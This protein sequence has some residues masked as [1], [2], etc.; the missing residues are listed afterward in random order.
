MIFLFKLILSALAL[1]NIGLSIASWIISNNIQ[2]RFPPVGEFTKING[3]KLHFVDT[4]KVD[5]DKPVVI[6]IHGAGGNLNDPMPIYRPALEQKL[7][8]VFLDRPGQGYSDSFDGSSNIEIQTSSIALLMEKLNIEKAIIVGHSFG[9]AI[10][11]SFAVLHP[12]KTTG[13]VLLAP[14]TH[15]WH[16]GV[17]WH[18]DLGN[19]P[20]IGWIFSNTIAP[21]AGSFI[22]PGAIKRLFQ[23]NQ[24]PQDYSETSATQLALVPRNFHANAKD[25]ARLH[26][27]VEA[28]E[29]RYSE[30]KAPTHIY[31]G[32][33]DDIVSLEI[34]SI[35][36]LSKDIKHAKLTILKDVGHKPDYVASDQIINS[37]LEIADLN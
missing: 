15:P 10:A 2:N 12:E 9:G 6:F 36:G 5:D 34:H 30:I 13:L 3:A 29:N 4:G 18:Y 16:T 33:A 20:V 28:F 22:Y 37:I 17:D 35:N 7:R 23:P 19:T 25:I 11:S 27:H 31:H 21:V 1:I 8:L 24:K 26:T 32:D 14:V